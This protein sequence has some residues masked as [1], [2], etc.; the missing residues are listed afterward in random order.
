[1]RSDGQKI[2]VAMKVIRVHDDDL[3]E[4]DSI[5]LKRVYDIGAPLPI[6]LSPFY[7]FGHIG[8]YLKSHPSADRHQLMHGVAIGLE[9]LHKNESFTGIWKRETSWSTS[10]TS[11]ASAISG[12]RES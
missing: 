8:N 7:K 2:L 6:F 9:Y 1:M 4:I 5:R 12:S 11:R 3:A 10:V